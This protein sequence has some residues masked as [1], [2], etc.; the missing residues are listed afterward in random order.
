MYLAIHSYIPRLLLQEL[1]ISPF[2]IVGAYQRNRVLLFFF[3]A[4]E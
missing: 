3:L 1:C 2:L 4:F